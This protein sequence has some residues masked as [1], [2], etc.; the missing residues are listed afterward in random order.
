MKT[1]IIF[2]EKCLGYG[3]WHIEGPQRVKMAH[4]ILKEK[5][6][7]FLE[8]TSASE[9]DLLKV[10]DYEYIWNLKKGLVDDSDT[11]AY[12]NIYEYARLSA[13]GAI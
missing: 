2:S 10:H 9:E 1:K 11:P 3:A 8:P 12:D 6:Y 7:D 5:G 4:E 13:G